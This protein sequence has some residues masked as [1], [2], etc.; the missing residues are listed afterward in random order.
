MA[1]ITPALDGR[2]G[3][4]RLGKAHVGKDIATAFLNGN[5]SHLLHVSGV[6]ISTGEIAEWWP[7]GHRPSLTSMYESILPMSRI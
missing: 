3:C 2:V 4:F 1:M 6:T 5:V 7:G